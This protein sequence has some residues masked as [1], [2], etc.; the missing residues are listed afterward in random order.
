MSRWAYIRMRLYSRGDYIRE[1]YGMYAK[2]LIYC[3]IVIVFI[4]FVK[5]SVLNAIYVRFLY[6]N[7]LLGIKWQ[8][9]KRSKVDIQ[10]NLSIADTIGS[11]KRCP[12]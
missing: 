12:L 9:S 4:A 11:Q 2:V 6:L 1:C 5:N 7:R 3:Q 10:L 8:Q